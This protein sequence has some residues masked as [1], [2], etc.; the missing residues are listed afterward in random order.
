M[1]VAPVDI[2]YYWLVDEYRDALTKAKAEAGGVEG[3]GR[4]MR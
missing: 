4:P 1:T 2:Y 3:T